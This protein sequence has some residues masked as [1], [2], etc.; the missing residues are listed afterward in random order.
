MAASLLAFWLNTPSPF[1]H[2]SCLSAHADS[3]SE[4]KVHMQDL[5]LYTVPFIQSQ[6]L[7]AK[8]VIPIR[9]T[10]VHHLPAQPRQ[11]DDALCLHRA[12]I[13]ASAVLLKPGGQ[14]VRVDVFV[15]VVRPTRHDANQRRF[16][17][18]FGREEAQWGARDGGADEP[19]AGFKVADCGLEELARGVDVFENFEEGDYV[20]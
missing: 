13:R 12:P 11:V 5:T 14:L 17:D 10:P 4:Y 19:A 1:D 9:F 16:G 6:S 8:E 15:P 7:D 20:C 2:C 18:E 3:T